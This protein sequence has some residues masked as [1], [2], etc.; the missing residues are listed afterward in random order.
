MP[1]YKGTLESYGFHFYRT[2]IMLHEDASIEEFREKA[3]GYYEKVTPENPRRVVLQPIKDVHLRSAG[4]KDYT[5]RSDIRYVYIFAATGILILLMAC[6][7]FINLTTAQS[8]A[9]AKEVGMRKVLGAYRNNIIRQFLSETLLFSLFS[10]GIAICL[11]IVFVPAYGSLTGKPITL[12]LSKNMEVKVLSNV[13]QFNP[14]VE[15]PASIKN[16]L[17]SNRRLADNSDINIINDQDDLNNAIVNTGAIPVENTEEIF[18][19]LTLF[20]ST[21]GNV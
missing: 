14:V 19:A 4:I 11:V 21:G 5:Q 10:L 16:I 15:A 2:Y 12:D 6:I 13:R 3:Y 1:S 18:H 17:P 20:L 8:G 9:R 7:N